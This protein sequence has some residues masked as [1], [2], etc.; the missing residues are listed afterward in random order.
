MRKIITQREKDRIR[1]RNQIIVGSILIFIMFFSALGYSFQGKSS[2]S[3]GEISYNGY[4]FVKNGNYWFTTIGDTGFAFS[5]NPIETQNVLFS[6]EM[7]SLDNYYWNPL[8]IFSDSKEAEIEI[9]SNLGQF[10][11]RVQQAC[12]ESFSNDERCKNLPVKNC[13]NNFIIMRHS[14]ATKIERD[15]NCIF[16]Y[17]DEENL[18]KATDAFLFKVL[19]VTS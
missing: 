7:P 13:E 17:S 3:E 8:Y 2:S 14:N 19:G 15:K 12:L 1:R 6:A 11:Q 10:V 4:K 5:Y 9:Y 18:T 16:I